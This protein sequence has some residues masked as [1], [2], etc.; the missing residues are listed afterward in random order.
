MTLADPHPVSLFHEKWEGTVGTSGFNPGSADGGTGHNARFIF[1]FDLFGNYVLKVKSGDENGTGSYHVLVRY[2]NYCIP[3]AD[4]G[5]LFPYEGGPE[6]YAFDVRNDT[7]TKHGVYDRDGGPS[8]YASKSHVL[9]DNWGS[10]PDEDWFRLEPRGGHRIRGL[11]GRPLL[12]SRGPSADEAPDRWHLRH[13]RK[14]GPR[15]RS[16]EWDRHVR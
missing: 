9:G 6:G 1:I 4:G 14:R 11:P 5:I 13:R 15:G 10:M 8:Y 12:C 16:R 3:R 7:D 2:D